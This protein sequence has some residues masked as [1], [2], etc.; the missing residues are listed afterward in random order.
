VI[1]DTVDIVGVNVVAVIAE[2]MADEKRNYD[3]GGEAE[4][5]ASDLDRSIQFLLCHGSP[6]YCDK[7]VVH[8]DIIL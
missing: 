4:R 3:A 2:L 5:K 8:T 6:G 1:D 7:V